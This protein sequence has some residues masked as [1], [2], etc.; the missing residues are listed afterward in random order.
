MSGEKISQHLELIDT[1]GAADILNV[2]PRTI[3]AWR[4]SGSGPGYFKVGH[5]VRYCRSE[6]IDWLN[7]N[8]RQN[9]TTAA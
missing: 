1:R 6:V 8:A 4:A 9:T 7:S 2:S 5:S 3:E